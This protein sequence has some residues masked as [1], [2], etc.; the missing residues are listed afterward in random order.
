MNASRQV[1]FHFSCLRSAGIMCLLEVRGRRLDWPFL[2]WPALA[3]CQIQMTRS[4]RQSSSPET[5][6]AY[7]ISCCSLCLASDPL[8][9]LTRTQC[10]SRA[11]SSAQSPCRRWAAALGEDSYEADASPNFSAS[12]KCLWQPMQTLAATPAIQTRLYIRL[13]SDY[14]AMRLFSGYNVKS[15]FGTSHGEICKTGEQRLHWPVRLDTW[16]NALYDSL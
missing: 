13:F 11:P 1:S 15:T 6:E 8:S 4:L 7:S 16:C 3:A 14:I 5:R 10:C 9:I 2:F 12:W